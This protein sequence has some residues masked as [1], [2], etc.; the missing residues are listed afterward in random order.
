MVMVVGIG[1]GVARIAQLHLIGD[2]DDGMNWQDCESKQQYAYWNGIM[3][4]HR[5]HCAPS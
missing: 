1:D 4:F 3:A 2:A 5:R